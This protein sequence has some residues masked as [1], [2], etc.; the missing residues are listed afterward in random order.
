MCANCIFRQDKKQI[1]TKTKKQ[2][3]HTHKKNTHTKKNIS[4]QSGTYLSVNFS[5]TP[6]SVYSS[7]L[8]QLVLRAVIAPIGDL[9]LFCRTGDLWSIQKEGPL[10]G[11]P[12]AGSSFLNIM[13]SKA[14]PGIFY[15]VHQCTVILKT[16]EGHP[17]V[18][19]R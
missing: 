13:P 6:I 10:F 9:V 11:D 15:T 2:K 17:C 3:T 19:R 8:R 16:R 5:R 14:V 1:K 12:Q 4:S 7:L 18:A